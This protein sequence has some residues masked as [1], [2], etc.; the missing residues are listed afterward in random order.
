MLLGERSEP[1]TG[2]FNRDFAIYICMW[3]RSVG[4]YVC[5]G[6]KCIGEIKWPTRM[7]KVILGWLKLTC[8]TSVIHLDYALEQLLQGQNRNVHLEMG[9]LKQTEL[10]RLKTEERKAEDKKH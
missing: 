5:R 9:N 6:P 7:L 4:R 8:D 3:G 2:V 10:Q 1:H